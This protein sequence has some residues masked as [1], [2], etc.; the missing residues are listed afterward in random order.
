MPSDRNHLLR[1]FLRDKEG[2]IAIL[3]ATMM[4]ALAMSVGAGLDYARALS[5]QKSMQMDLDA[6]ILSGAAQGSLDALTPDQITENYFGDN[7]SAKHNSGPV[8]LEIEATDE[9]I[10]ANAN[11]NVPTTLM[12]LAGVNEIP[13]SAR[14]KV[15]FGGKP[16]EIALVLDNTGSMLGEKLE[17]LKSAANLLVQTAYGAASSQDFVKVALVPFSQYV[18][19][20]MDNRNASWIEVPLDSSSSEEVCGEVTPITGQSNCRTQT[21]TWMQD[22]VSQSSKYQVCDYDYGPAE[23]QCSTQTT[24]NTWHGCVGSRDH[25]LNVK[26]EQYGT[27]VPGIMNVSCASEIQP[28]TNNLDVLGSKIGS[29]SASG[30]TYI[31]AGLTWGWRLL[32]RNEPFSQGASANDGTRK[33]LVLMTDGANTRSPSYPKHDLADGELSDTLTL[34]LCENIKAAGIEV[35]T[36]AFDVEDDNVLDKMKS[37]ASDLTNFFDAESGDQLSSAFQKIGRSTRVVSLAE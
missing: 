19:V 9:A 33:M 5:V 28:L 4:A 6:A 8:T 7:W 35:F 17:N 18:N 10:T 21:S 22:G 20:G 12:K 34:E 3:F 31:P 2:A 25:P 23:Y 14:S 32:S 15:G 16:V 24:S 11:S 36:V 27:K 13:V 30:D 26:D 37:C 1:G 29:M